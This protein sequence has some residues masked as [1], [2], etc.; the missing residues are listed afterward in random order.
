MKKHLL[1]AAILAGIAFVNPA[2]A[3][4]KFSINIGSQPAWG[5]TGYDHVE[6]YYLPDVEAYYYVPKHQF[7]YQRGG[8]W[9]FANDLP[10]RYHDFDLYHSH[11][12]VIND[13][14]PYMHFDE[15]RKMYDHF[16]GEHDRQEAIRTSHDNRYQ[17]HFHDR[18]DNDEDRRHHDDH[19]GHH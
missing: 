19:G 6:Y 5:P 11:K 14:K 7:V 12:V 10:A 18:R 17:N 4:I 1:A 8:R 2:Q 16:R 3:Q 13:P 9:V 15:H